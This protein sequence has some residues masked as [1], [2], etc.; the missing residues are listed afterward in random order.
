MVQKSTI[1]DILVKKGTAKPLQLKEWEKEAQ[2]QKKE[3]LDIL[4]EKI[5]EKDLTEAKAEFSGFPQIDILEKEIQAEAL[6]E[7]PWEAVNHYK[8]IP[9]SKKD[10]ILTVGMVNPEDNKAQEALRFIGLRKNFKIKIHTITPSD[11]KKALARYRGLREEVEEAL[12]G[13]EEELGLKASLKEERL[14]EKVGKIVAEAPITKL[15]GVIIRHAVEGKASD[16]HIEPMENETVVRFRVDGLLYTS[17]K[18][19]KDLHSAIISRIKILSNLKIDESRVP[20]DGRFQTK[21]DDK[22][23]DF[24]VSTLPTFYG[25]KVALRILDPAIG[26][27]TFEELGIDGQNLK[28]LE[29]GI[30]KPFGLVLISGPTGSG[31]STT[32]Y[33]VLNVLNQENVNIIALEDP[34][35]YYIEGVNQSQIRPEIDYSFATGLRHILRQD[36]DIIMVGEI[37]DKET[38]GL[39]THAALTGHLVF[40]TI[41]TNDA[42]GVIPRLIDMGIEPFL[43]VSTLNLAIAQRL[44]KRLCQHCKEKIAA[45]P[46]ITKIIKEELIKIKENPLIEQSLGILKEPFYIYKSKGCKFCYNKGTKGRIGVFEMIS[47]TPELEKILNDSPTETS[48]SKE[49]QRQGM[50]SMKQDG[51][52]KVL[53]GII[54][55]EELIKVV[56]I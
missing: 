44:A 54:S 16:I 40:S 17:L 36:P 52:I 46:P 30:K 19:S 42:L 1:L 32:L 31:K 5:S 6:R 33:A 34:I 10:N 50:I 39:V 20:Q 11:F 26:L 56:E 18:L 24:R 45:P 4:S 15:V 14:E 55:F 3:I 28:M 12:R 49:A 29:G 35:E 2:N 9:L 41:H 23:I 22:K 7:I 21:V 27:K 25:E 51:I 38:A 53:K 37:R 8:F 47:M 48:I 13:V 43:I